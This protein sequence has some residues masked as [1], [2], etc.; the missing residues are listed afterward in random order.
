MDIRLLQSTL[1][2]LCIYYSCICY[3][4]DISFIIISIIIVNSINGPNNDFSVDYIDGAWLLTRILFLLKYKR[5]RSYK[6]RTISDGRQ[7][8]SEVTSQLLGWTVLFV[9]NSYLIYFLWSCAR[10]LPPLL[11]KWKA[12]SSLQINGQSQ[13]F[14]SNAINVNKNA[15]NC[16]T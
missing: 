1:N 15:I 9:F 3:Y 8:T 6:G 14:L 4:E 11:R 7:A 12:S 10:V 13:S 2:L 16:A 5:H